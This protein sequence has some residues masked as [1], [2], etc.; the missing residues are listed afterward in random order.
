MKKLIVILVVGALFF[1]SSTLASV[2]TVPTHGNDSSL[3]AQRL[4]LQN[5]RYDM[6]II[7]PEKFSNEIQPLL[8]HKNEYG[9][10]TIL[11]TTEEIYDEYM[12]RDKA[13]QIKYFIKDAIEQWGISYVLLIGGKKGQL[14]DWY[15]P[16]R[17]VHLDDGFFRY[18][19]Y[20]SDLYFADIY[21]NNRTEFDDWDSNG[22]GIFG[23][24]SPE[25]RDVLD[26]H[27]DVAVG[28]L[29]CRNKLEVK[30]MVD[31]IISYETTAYGQPWFNHMVLVGGD[32]NPGVGN[33]F[34]Y[35]GEVTCDIAAGYMNGFNFTK[36]YTSDGSLTGHDDVIN[37]MN[38]GCGFIFFS[39]HGSTT[40]WGTYPPDGGN[41]IHGISTQDVLQLKNKNMYPVSVISAC[42][43]AKFD[44]CIGNYFKQASEQ[45]AVFECLSW[46]LT[47]KLDGGSIATIASTS[48]P[49][50]YTG[51]KDG[52][53]IFD[54]VEN[55]LTHWFTVELF[56]LYGEERK[57]TL[58]DIY[59][60]A[61]ENYVDNFPGMKNKYDCKTVQEFALLGDPSLRIGGYP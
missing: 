24:F 55:G 57:R 54:G 26:L 2:N 50:G 34:P 59:R 7:A 29:P 37:A 27:P 15:V 4:F 6:V 35:E 5:N 39:G 22:N 36:L 14:F 12:G 41:I 19:Y 32:T 13:E 46:R 60:T 45:D 61:I 43:T 52:D 10:K 31:K 53:G 17:Y 16:V 25:D 49:W 20:L 3:P 42:D 33:P 56:R 8:T 23:E 38:Q 9:I 11:K 28:R 18:P 30:I 21:K 51:D 1:E 47:R 48:T 40:A 44:V 58:G